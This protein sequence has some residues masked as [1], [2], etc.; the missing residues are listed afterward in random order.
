MDTDIF[1]LDHTSETG[2]ADQLADRIRTAISA[3]A[4]PHGKAIPSIREIARLCG[5]SLRVPRE[6]IGR[7]TR[8]GLLIP[9]RGL[10]TTVNGK[11]RFARRGHVLLI[12][13]NDFGAYYLGVLIETIDKHLTSAGYL[14]SRIAVSRNDRERYDY[15]PLTDT[16]RRWKFTAAL[17][18]AFDDSVF[19]PLG[20]LN[21]PYIASSYL[22]KRYHGSNGRIHCA[23]NAALPDFIA[24]C[25]KRG[26][27]TVWQ[28]APT[29]VLEML[30][31]APGLNAKGIRTKTLTVSM[32]PADIGRQEF[33][34]R[35][36]YEML[37]HQLSK[38]KLP[39]LL[40]V[41][42]DFAA[43]GVILALTEQ[44]VRFPEDVQLVSWVNHRFSPITPK[45]LTRMEMD[46]F[47]HG[48][49]IAKA[50][51]AFLRDGKFPKDISIGPVYRRGD[52][53]R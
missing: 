48:K 16:V 37:R 13:P 32:P 39:D 6:A 46:P 31:A 15:R 20:E 17:A 35:R 26:I 53:F 19:H 4:L 40:F 2:L 1:S 36:A 34:E 8:E 30:D 47:T 25:T 27:R 14:V 44:G 22:P 28:I 43:R 49:M 50:F 45:P 10:G 38:D 11:R 51:L 12:S 41:S 33:V 3:G 7:L 24:H 9:R 52:S 21:I 29:S 5:T 23:Y 42:D 18:F